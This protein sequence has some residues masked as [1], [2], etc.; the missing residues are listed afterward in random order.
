MYLIIDII[1]CQDFFEF[2]E[3][4]ADV[5]SVAIAFMWTLAVLI[6][7]MNI[8]V[9]V[10]T[11]RLK[12]TST[13]TKITM[14]SLAM[15][16]MGVGIQSFCR[17]SYFTLSGQYYFAK[18]F[19]CSIDCIILCTF[20][21]VSITTIMYLCIDRVITIKCP[22]HYPVYF[23]KSVVLCIHVFI[24]LFANTMLIVGHYVLGFEIILIKE[25]LFCSFVPK[26][27][28]KLTSTVLILNFTLPVCVIFI[29]AVILLRTV[30]QQI[31]QIR[32][33][34]SRMRSLESESETTSRMGCL[35]SHKRAIRTIFCMVAG[36]YI[37]CSPI[38][39]VLTMINLFGFFFSP[40]VLAVTSWIAFSN[41]ML[42]SLV[43]LPTMREYREIFKQ[44]FVPKKYSLLKRH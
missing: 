32:A 2:S 31:H 40:Y 28:S 4:L 20:C 29:C 23:T 1:N 21:A 36:Y 26:H 34:E 43:Y 39:I 16:D 6:I 5:N 9:F 13:A 8:P 3:K 19:I 42:N 44:I 17:L 24:W 37:C 12:E 33:L 14:I 22:L 11:P 25:A 30:N 15:T 41:S 35:M 10:V 27:G 7:L 18:D 38:M